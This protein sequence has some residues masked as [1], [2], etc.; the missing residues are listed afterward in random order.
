MRS[1]APLPYRVRAELFSQLAA[2]EK[3]GLPAAKAW[4]LVK[5]TGVAPVRLKFIHKAIA[6]GSSPAAAA[7]KARLF[8]PLE[9][10]IVLAAQVAGSPAPAYQRLATACSQRAQIEGKVRSRMVLPAVTLFLALLIQP[11]PQL[12]TGAINEGAY[13]WQIFKPLLFLASLATATKWILE[14]SQFSRL[15]LKLPI[16]GPVIARQNALNF[17]ESLG[18][19]L[20]SGVPMFEAL[21]TA[22]TTIQNPDIK[23]NYIKIKPAMLRGVPLSNAL[24]DVIT[25]PLHLGNLHV[26]EFAVTGESSGTLPEMLLWHAKAETATL[27]HFWQQV[28][29]WLPRLAYAAIAC[30]MMY[31][32]QTDGTDFRNASGDVTLSGQGNTGIP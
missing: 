11:L 6:K 9:S 12:L 1:S 32:L 19:L 25:E 5:L 21:P 20:D 4:E 30:W 15:L 22:V 31:G 7:Q 28:A 3:T 17:F 13:L 14:S 23:K 29:D 18:L 24:S 27:I 8:T 2:L 10:S 26:I 16:F